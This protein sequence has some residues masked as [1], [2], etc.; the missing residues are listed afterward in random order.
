[1]TTGPTPNKRI[2]QG[3]GASLSTTCFYFVAVGHMFLLYGPKPYGPKPY[4]PKPYG[5]NHMLQN[6]MAQ[7]HMLQNHILQ[8]HMLQKHMLDVCT[9]PPSLPREGEGA[10]EG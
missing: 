7:N 9:N 4:A 5:A 2:S 1:M 6:H 8:N 10:G 3:D